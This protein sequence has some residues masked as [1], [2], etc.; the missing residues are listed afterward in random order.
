MSDK[1]KR[2][3]TTIETREVW[4]IRTAVP[5]I[6]E[7]V[8]MPT[9]RDIAQT[10]AVSQSNEADNGSETQLKETAGIQEDFQAIDLVGRLDKTKKEIK[11]K[12]KSS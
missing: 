12:N 11:C 9:P 6:S 8:E 10:A 1:K 7:E 4:I 5:E 2:T 3:V